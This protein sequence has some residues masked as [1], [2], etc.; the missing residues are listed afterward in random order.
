V[1]LS[2][3]STGTKEILNNLRINGH[4]VTPWLEIIFSDIGWTLAE[5][6]KSFTQELSP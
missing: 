4:C 5:K 3:R 2:A 1:L 6:S